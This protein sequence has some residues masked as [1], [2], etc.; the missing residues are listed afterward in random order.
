MQKSECNSQSAG[1]TVSKAKKTFDRV[2]R[3]H[4]DANIR[5]DDL[6]TLLLHLGFAERVRGGHH[7]FTRENVL[8]IVNLQPRN[9]RAK[10]YQVKQVRSIL[11][12]YGIAAHIVPEESTDG[13]IDPEP[14]DFEECDH[15]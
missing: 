6:R 3:G 1:N 5:F 11:N 10:P 12:T 2:M 7:I 15:E 14:T 4:S 8:E 9:G 13:Q